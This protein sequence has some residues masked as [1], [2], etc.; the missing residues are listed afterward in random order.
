MAEFMEL[1]GLACDPE[2]ELAEVERAI[3]R[4]KGL[5]LSD[6]Q[7]SRGLDAVMGTMEW[8]DPRHLV[9]KR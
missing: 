8:R 2:V 3:E 9:D 5:D 1:D 4:W 6:E 7:R